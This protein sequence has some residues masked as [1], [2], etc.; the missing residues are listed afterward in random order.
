MKHF[1]RLLFN[2]AI[3]LAFVSVSYFVLSHFE[4]SLSPA[5]IKS[6]N[7]AGQNVKVDLAITV[8]EQTRGLS[9]RQN[10]SDNTG[11]LFV[12][13]KPEKY[14][15]WMKDMNFPL[16]IIWIGEDMKVVY[17]KENALPELYPETYRPTAPSKYVLEVPSGFSTKNNLK[18]GDS[19]SFT[20]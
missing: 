16:D 6:I 18:V 19:V 12:F 9:G 15:F 17:I 20:Y 4:K 14:L 5:K 8:D 7:I 13:N 2:L 3:I 10:M 11:M 1:W